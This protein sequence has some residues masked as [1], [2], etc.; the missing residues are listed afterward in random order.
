[1]SLEESAVAVVAEVALTE[2]IL[3]EWERF[4]LLR[5]RCEPL[6]LVSGVGIDLVSE[7]NREPEYG[8]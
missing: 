8:R 3:A 5:I 1:M 2:A 4:Y 6:F 7:F